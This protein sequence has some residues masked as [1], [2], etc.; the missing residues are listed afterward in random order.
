MSAGDSPRL[1]CLRCAVR[2]CLGDWGG[3]T[4]GDDPAHVALGSFLSPQSSERRAVSLMSLCRLSLLLSLLVPLP[5]LVSLCICLFV[6]VSLCLC[7]SFSLSLCLLYVSISFLFVQMASHVSPAA[8]SFAAVSSGA[9]RCACTDGM[10]CL[11]AYGFFV[12]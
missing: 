2:G 7:L 8:V 4:G 3:D 6:S 9:S 10:R 12:W 1:L 5:L 11:L